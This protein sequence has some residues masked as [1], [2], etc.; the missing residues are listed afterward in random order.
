MILADSGIQI[1]QLYDLVIS[2]NV[3]EDEIQGVVKA[4]FHIIR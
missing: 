3:L 1:A 4:I 2:Q